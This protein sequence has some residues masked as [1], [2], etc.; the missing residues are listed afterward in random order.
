MSRNTFE[1]NMNNIELISKKSLL[2][3][4]CRLTMLN[5][6]SNI[7]LVML[8]CFKLARW[9]IIEYNSYQLESHCMGIKKYIVY[10][11]GL[12]NKELS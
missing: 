12:T 9:Q 5:V 8:S 10:I 7:D 3:Q 1:G 2:Y 4:T 11:F 6:W